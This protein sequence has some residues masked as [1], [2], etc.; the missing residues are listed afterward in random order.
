MQKKKTKQ[1]I[2]LQPY[3][4]I[5]DIRHLLSVSYATAK[6]IYGYA[7][8]LDDAEL[9]FCIEPTKVRMTSVCKVTGQSLKTIKTLAEQ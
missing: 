7:K 9:K 8:E 2:A 6:R 3:L 4:C 1:E 5:N